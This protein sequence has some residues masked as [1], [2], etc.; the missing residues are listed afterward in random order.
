LGASEAEFTFSALEARL[1]PSAQTLLHSVV[2]A[3]DTGEEEVLWEQ[4]QACVRRLTADLRK[5]EIDELRSR[6]KMAEREGQIKEALSLM[7]ELRM[8]ELS[9]PEKD[10]GET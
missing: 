6:I 2:S 10:T 9:R 3:D 4:A 8:A 5:R 1:S 7:A